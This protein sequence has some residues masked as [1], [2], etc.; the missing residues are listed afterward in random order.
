MRCVRVRPHGLAPGGAG[1]ASIEMPFRGLHGKERQPRGCRVP[2]LHLIRCLD[3]RHVIAGEEARLKL[4]YPVETLQ[5][6]ARG[7]TRNALL[8]GALCETTIVEGAELRGS[9]A[10]G[11]GER[12]WRGKAVEEEPAPPQELQSVLG[13]ALELVE[14]TAQCQKSGAETARGD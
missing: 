2:F 9:P 1:Q 11:P 4:S 6:G 13:F 7:L 14:R 8:E 3:R 12:D 10:Q 5:E